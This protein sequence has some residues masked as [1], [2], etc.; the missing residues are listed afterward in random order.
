MLL[1]PEQR[2]LRSCLLTVLLSA[3]KAPSEVGA[4]YGQGV[5]SVEDQHTPIVGP[6][7]IRDCSR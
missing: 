7:M 6:D 5:G 4:G 3:T 2:L 1:L